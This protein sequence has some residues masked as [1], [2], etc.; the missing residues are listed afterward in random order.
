MFAHGSEARDAQRRQVRHSSFDQ[1]VHV[2]A[3][4]VSDGGGGHAGLD[5]AAEL[6]QALASGCV[7]IDEL[8]QAQR[9]LRNRQIKLGCRTPTDSRLHA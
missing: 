5:L 7:V 8:E 3:V 1:R 9:R 6:R 2:G 4:A